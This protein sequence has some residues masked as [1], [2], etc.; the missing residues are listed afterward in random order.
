MVTMDNLAVLILLVAV[1]IGWLGGDH[2]G[3]NAR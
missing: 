1:L 3:P 2:D